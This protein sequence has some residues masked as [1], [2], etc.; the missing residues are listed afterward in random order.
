ML[1]GALASALQ[2][3]IPILP[4]IIDALCRWLRR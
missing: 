2:A 1:A 4:P 3:I